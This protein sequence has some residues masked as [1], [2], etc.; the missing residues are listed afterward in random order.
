MQHK[1]HIL[2]WASIWNKNHVLLIHRN[3][4]L[5]TCPGNNICPLL[6]NLIIKED[7]KHTLSNLGYISLNFAE[8]KPNKVR[9]SGINWENSSQIV[10]EIDL[11]IRPHWSNSAV[12]INRGNKSRY[13]HRILDCHVISKIC[14]PKGSP[15]EVWQV[16]NPRPIKTR[17]MGG[18]NIISTNVQP[19]WKFRPQ[20]IELT[21]FK[22][23]L[24]IR[25]I[26]NKTC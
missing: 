3:P 25:F 7:I 17:I 21:S 19:I 11:S 15:I 6:S 12:D 23:K 4:I 13:A 24:L 26:V 10:I 18:W 20:L 8:M 9:E 2:L 14:N 16:I 1:P 22:L 5:L